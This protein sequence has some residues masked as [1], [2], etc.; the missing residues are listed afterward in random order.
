MLVV[1]T[2]DLRPR[3]LLSDTRFQLYDRRFRTPGR[4]CRH[5]MASRGPIGS[6]DNWE[7]G[8]PRRPGEHLPG[9]DL[10]D[11]S[12]ATSKTQ[13]LRQ[14]LRE[15]NDR[16]DRRLRDHV[17]MSFRTFK[18]LKATTQLV[19]MIGG[20]YAMKQGVDPWWA[21]AMMAFIWGGPEGIE[22]LLESGGANSTE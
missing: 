11:D 7:T 20:V 9:G 4:I 16:A 2:D 14:Q 19:G 12:M 10:L 1:E 18:V 13:P 21:L 22:I 17:G 15:C 5:K 3:Q 6:R 8:Y